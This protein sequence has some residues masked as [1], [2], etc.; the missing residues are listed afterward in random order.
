MTPYEKCLFQWLEINQYARQLTRSGL[1]PAATVLFEN[2]FSGSPDGLAS[3][4]RA[5]Y[6][7]EPFSLRIGHVDRHRR[8][9][10]EAPRFPAGR[11]LLAAV[12]AA[13]GDFGYR[14]QDLELD[15]LGPKL[16]RRYAGLSRC[17][18]GIKRVLQRTAARFIG[19]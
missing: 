7:G 1:A 3:L 11:R 10:K 4:Y 17:T 5:A 6:A 9:I 14:P 13:A 16:A 19:A 15:L 18:G 8:R 12:R 2:L